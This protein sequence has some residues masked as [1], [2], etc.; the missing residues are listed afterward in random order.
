M[1]NVHTVEVCQTLEDLLGE[2]LDQLFLETSLVRCAIDRSDRASRYIF[3]E[4]TG[5]LKSDRT[6]LTLTDDRY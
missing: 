2:K 6:K 4:T 1:P 3:Q 5:Q